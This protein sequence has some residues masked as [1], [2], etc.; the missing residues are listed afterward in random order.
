MKP[1]RNILGNIN[2]RNFLEFVS[3]RVL[4][5]EGVTTLIKNIMKPII[6]LYT[7]VKAKNI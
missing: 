3:S 2:L 5:T 1:Y 4:K 7:I 6:R